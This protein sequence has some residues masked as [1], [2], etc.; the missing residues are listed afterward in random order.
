MAAKKRAEARLSRR[1]PYD[2]DKDERLDPM[3]VLEEVMRH[4]YRKAKIDAPS[5][6]ALPLLRCPEG[7]HLLLGA[8]PNWARFLQPFRMTDGVRGGVA[9][10]RILAAEG[11]DDAAAERARRAQPP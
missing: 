9:K 3:A 6:D 5:N 10:R 7:N 11:K 8:I 4:F 2:L 1:V